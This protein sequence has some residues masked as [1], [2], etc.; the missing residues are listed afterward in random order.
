MLHTY[1]PVRGR[2]KTKKTAHENHRERQSIESITKYEN[3]TAD[4]L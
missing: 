3:I 1:P 2:L 4:G